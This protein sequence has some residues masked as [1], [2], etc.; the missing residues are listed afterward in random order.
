M[1]ILCPK[2]SL[3]LKVLNMT[4]VFQVVDWD[5]LANV[6]NARNLFKYK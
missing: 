2:I 1:V 4:F 5:E 6:A 3:I